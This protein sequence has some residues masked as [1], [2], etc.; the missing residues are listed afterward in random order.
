[1]PDETL[2]RTTVGEPPLAGIDTRFHT[3]LTALKPTCMDAPPGED[4]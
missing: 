2:V 3:L 1:M 4:R